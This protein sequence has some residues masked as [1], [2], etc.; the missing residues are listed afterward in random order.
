MRVID[1]STVP[2]LLAVQL[3][4]CASTGPSPDA[5]PYQR[6]RLV[7]LTADDFGA[8]ENINDGIVFALERGAITA[9]SALM[10][11]PAS[12]GALRNLAQRFPRVGIGV[13]FNLITGSPVLDPRHV[14][15][16]VDGRG[17]FLPVDLLLARIRTI[18]LADVELELRAQ[19]H[20]VDEL[21]ITLDHLSDHNGILSLYP[22]FFEVFCRI[23][24][25]RGVPVRSPLTASMKYPRLFPDAGAVKKGKALAAQV[26]GRSLVAAMGLL[27]YATLGSMEKRVARLDDLGIPHPAILIDYLYGN[28]TPFTAMHILRNLPEGV[29]EIVVHLGTSRRSGPYPPGLDV[30]YFPTREQ[31]L[32]IVTSESLR[33]Y[34]KGLNI[35]AVGFQDL[36]SLVGGE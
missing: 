36:A 25:E 33:E 1:R 19:V 20:A 32:A 30:G 12:R 23:A 26:A 34:A 22:P 6:E 31:E 2:P 10:N 16:L 9:V 17:N 35:R 11:F 8:S 21:G 15:S 13:H 4:S 28:P 27:P 29:S 7:I 5:A 3:R 24:K 18:R 14:P